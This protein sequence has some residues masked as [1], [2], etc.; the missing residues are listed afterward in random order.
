MDSPIE[1]GNDIIKCVFF[2]HSRGGG[3][4]GIHLIQC[5]SAFLRKNLL[6]LKRL[7]FIFFKIDNR[8]F[9]MT[10]ISNAPY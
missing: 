7:L 10:I 1:S 2:R 8:F 9:A 5:S 6:F 4:P 3:N